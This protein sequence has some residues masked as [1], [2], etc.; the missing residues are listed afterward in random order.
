MFHQVFGDPANP[1]FAADECF[2]R[3]P[4]DLELLLAIIFFSFRDFLEIG[5]DLRQLGFRPAQLGNAAFEVDR[6]RRLVD[7]LLLDVI[8][9]NVLAEHGPCIGVGLFVEMSGSA[10]A[11]GVARKYRGWRFVVNKSEET[12]A[13]AAPLREAVLLGQ[14]LRWCDL[15]LRHRSLA[16]DSNPS[17][18]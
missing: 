11:A 7:D 1:L 5:I 8:D 12:A 13:S 9:R 3:G 10:L 14:A 15:R 17:T 18:R 6:H 4:L 2:E 16:N